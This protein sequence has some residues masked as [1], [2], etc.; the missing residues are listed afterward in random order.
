MNEELKFRNNIRHMNHETNQGTTAT[1][2]QLKQQQV[3]LHLPGA[4]SSL[5]RT[6]A[7]E[8]CPL[9]VKAL[10]SR[11]GPIYIYIYIS[12][13]VFVSVFVYVY[14]YI[15]SKMPAYLHFSLLV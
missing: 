15:G 1:N 3:R 4:R 9:L 11:G 7:R 2:Q 13:F 5:A 8:S 12:V 10:R 14:T 6:R